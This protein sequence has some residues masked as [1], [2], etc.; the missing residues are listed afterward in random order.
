LTIVRSLLPV[1]PVMVETHET[2]F[3]LADRYGLA[4]IAPSAR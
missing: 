1:V 4:M 2:G 3:D